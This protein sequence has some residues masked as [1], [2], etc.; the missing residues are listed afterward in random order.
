[1]CT[2]CAQFS[3]RYIPHFALGKMMCFFPHLTIFTVK[4]FYRLIS[5]LILRCRTLVGNDGRMVSKLSMCILINVIILKLQVE[6]INNND[7]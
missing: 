2:I 6:K 5:D 3:F 4:C 1:M 7:Q